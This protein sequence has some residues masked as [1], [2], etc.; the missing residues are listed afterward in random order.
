[1]PITMSGLTIYDFDGDRLSGHW[2]SCD[3]LGVGMQFQAH[4][5]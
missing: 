2:Q 5:G 4:A 1:M 3:R